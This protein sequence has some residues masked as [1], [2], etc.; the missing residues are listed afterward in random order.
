MKTFIIAIKD[1]DH[2]HAKV[3]P[4]AREHDLGIEWISEYEIRGEFDAIHV[5][6]ATDIAP[7]EKFGAVLHANLGISADIWPVVEHPVSREERIDEAS[8]ESFPASD[9]PSITP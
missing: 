3:Q 5:V 4:L 1:K 9:P 2:S 8:D 7:L 6:K